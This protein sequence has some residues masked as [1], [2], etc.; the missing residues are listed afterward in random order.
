MIDLLHL[1]GAQD[2]Y[3]AKQFQIHALKQGI[4]GGLLGFALTLAT[5]IPLGLLLEDSGG[6]LLPESALSASDWALLLALPLPGCGFGYGDGA[7]DRAL[8]LS[9]PSLAMVARRGRRRWV[10]RLVALLLLIGLP[11]L[12]GLLWFAQKLPAEVAAPEQRTDAI[13]VLTGGSNRIAQGMALLAAG[14]G[15]KLFISGV[16]R[17]VEVDELL[18]RGRQ[19]PERFSCCIDLGYQADN[20]RGNAL[21]TAAWMAEE[22]Y[23][24]L[25]LVTANYHMPR[26]LV[27]FRRALP[28]AEVLPHPVFP[29]HFKQ[30]DWWRWPGSASLMISEYNKFLI[31]WLRSWIAGEG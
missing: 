10:R 29:E 6:G 4:F 26:S 19:A 14:K 28:D 13:V 11:W 25:R 21:E 1:I 20:T 16:Y 30:N 17:G 3:I 24:S 9:P 23:R 12:A 15:E 2:A 8:H 7:P 5:L 22:G 27:E 18:R 31:A